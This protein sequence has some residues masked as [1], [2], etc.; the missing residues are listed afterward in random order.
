M[1]HYESLRQRIIDLINE[2]YKAEVGDRVYY[3]SR[4]YKS[5]HNEGTIA[6]LRTPES[7]N[8]FKIKWD[9]DEK[10]DTWEVQYGAS[11]PVG[12]NFCL[13]RNKA[14]IDATFV[15]MEEL[16]NAINRIN[17]RQFIRD[18]NAEMTDAELMKKH[19]LNKN[20]YDY[21][22]DSPHIKYAFS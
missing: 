3:A 5:T 4:S 13:L 1:T 7:R 19:V 20:E 2:T 16:S 9:D 17:F 6:E 8:S 18:I 21:I 15:E 12:C 10:I 11:S 22:I 14:I